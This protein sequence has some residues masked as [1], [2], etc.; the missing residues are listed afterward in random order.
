[1]DERVTVYILDSSV[2]IAIAGQEPGNE[3]LLQYLDAALIS[4][5]NYSEVLQKVAQHGGSVAT[6]RSL[7]E[8]LGLGVVPFDDIMAAESAALWPLTHHK[9]LSL[10]DRA[11]L[12]LTRAVHGIAVTADR[13]WVDLKLPDVT[14]HV[15]DR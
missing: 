7:V 13:A 8:G 6:S 14:V 4:A 15:I 12:A 3:S 10:A 2:I 5:V 9:G 1:V 11:C